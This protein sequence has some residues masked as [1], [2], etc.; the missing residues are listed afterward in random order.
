MTMRRP[1]CCTVLAAV[2]LAGLPAMLR[3]Q[4]PAPAKAAEVRVIQAPDKCIAPDVCM[5]AK[6]VLH[7]VYGLEPHAYYVRSTDNGGHLHAPRAGWTAP[8]R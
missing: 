5:D 1:S 2:M 7:M 6:G 4:T 3:A 8:N